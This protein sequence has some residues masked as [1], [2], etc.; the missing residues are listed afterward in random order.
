M[1]RSPLRSTPLY[2]SAA[3]DV[4][5][6]QDT[7]SWHL[8]W[9]PT[10][11]YG[12]IGAT[13]TAARLLGL[14]REQSMHAMGIAAS[15]AC[16]IQKN[17][18]TMTKPL[19]AGLAARNGVFAA[20]LAQRGFTADTDALGGEQGFLRAFKGPGNYTEELVCA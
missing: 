9:H 11:P 7:K 12:T 18:G 1:I 16:G 6:R 14:T 13:C 17:F 2:S 19:H 8:G 4:Y 20:L 15:E 3:S 10:G 5:K